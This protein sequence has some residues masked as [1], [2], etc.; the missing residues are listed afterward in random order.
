MTEKNKPSPMEFSPHLKAMGMTLEQVGGGDARMRL[1]YR[2]D[3]VGFTDSGI[4][5]GGAI[6]TLIDS[7]CGAAVFSA[8]D[9]LQPIATLDLRLD[10]LKPATPQQPVYADGH[11]I[12]LTRSIAFVRA[13]AYHDDPAQ[14]IAN[15]AG[16]FVVK[17]SGKEASGG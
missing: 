6:Y 17:G 16:T 11:C 2:A 4:L 8:L 10:Y 3:L 7:V 12:K 14:P 9:Q 15:A 1:D 13:V 5:A